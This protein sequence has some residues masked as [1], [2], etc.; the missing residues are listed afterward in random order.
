[1]TRRALS[2]VTPPDHTGHGCHSE[3]PSARCTWEPTTAE[4]GQRRQA[5]LPEKW[6]G[7]WGGRGRPSEEASW[8][9][10]GLSLSPVAT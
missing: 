5:E 4:Q 6:H 1:M 2:A 3:A 8:P 9:H 7:R 10:C